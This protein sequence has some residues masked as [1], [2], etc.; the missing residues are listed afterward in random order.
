VNY[1]R[2]YMGLPE[3]NS[4]LPVIIYDYTETGF[5]II[6]LTDN[7]SRNNYERNYDKS[8]VPNL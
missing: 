7:A 2:G 3:L 6:Y 5:C 8:S 1:G 4:I